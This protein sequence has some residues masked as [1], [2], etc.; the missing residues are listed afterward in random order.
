M[1]SEKFKTH[2]QNIQCDFKNDKYSLLVATKAFGMG[3][4][5][6]NIF[7]TIHYG[8]PSSIEALYQEAGRAGRWDKRK[9]ENKKKV[10]KCYV[11]HSPEIYD[12]ETIGRLYHKDTTFAE[13]RAINDKI[14]RDGRDVFAQVFLFIQG[15]NDVAADFDIILEL[16]GHFFEE[17]SKIKIFWTDAYSKLKIGPDALEKAIYR[18]SLLGITSDWTTD[19][20]SHFEVQFNSLDSSQIIQNV[21][22]Y[23]TKYEP[24]TNVKSELQ[25]APKSSILEK[26]VWY[27]L[28][29]TFEN[30][31]YSRKQSLKTIS[32]WCL[33][34]KDSESFKRRIDSYFIFSEGTF[35]LQHI[36]ENPKEYER[37]FEVLIGNR[38]FLSKMEFEKLRDSISRFLESYRNNMG[39]NFVSGF[40]RLALDDYEDNDG[41]ERFESALSNI[42]EI[43]GS[44]EQG[45]ILNRV[46]FLGDHLLERQRVKL[47]QSITKFHPQLLDELAEYYQ[48]P[49]LLNDVYE[50]KLKELK[51][52]NGKLY[53]R[54]AEI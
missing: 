34:F 48:L 18:L 30:I 9:E 13:M 41:K 35:V 33:E 26:A 25:K 11:L 54:L 6:Q 52:L 19:F 29:W 5:K 51:M 7:Y 2:K 1:T 49:Y 31:A 21:S 24:D 39:L 38:Q 4:D 36:A 20:V 50:A 12:E 17:K 15:Q 16:I 53:E 3:I 22:N 14:K 42:K 28:N 46:K 47:C 45:I 44:K 43:F 10:G 32:D 27:L 23:I 40:V 37:W 8:L